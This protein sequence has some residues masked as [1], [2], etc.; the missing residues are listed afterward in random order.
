[1]QRRGGREPQG[2]GITAISPPSVCALFTYPVVRESYST[3]L[4]CTVVT[5]LGFGAPNPSPHIHERPSEFRNCT[6]RYASDSATTVTKKIIHFGLLVFT[7]NDRLGYCRSLAR[8]FRPLPLVRP[9]ISDERAEI[10][11]CRNFQSIR[12]TGEQHIFENP[13][14]YIRHAISSA[15]GLVRASA[16]WSVREERAWPHPGS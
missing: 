1:M 14:S 13:W 10:A 6:A 11:H 5:D 7:P 15:S 9:P 8:P 3:W 16:Y 2:A 4:F 12:S